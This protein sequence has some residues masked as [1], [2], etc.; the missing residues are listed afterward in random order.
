ME[1]GMKESYRKG[2]ANHPGPESCECSGNDA[3]EA[4]TGVYAGFVLSS[5]ITIP[6][7]RRGQTVRKATR[8]GHYCEPQA[9]PAESKTRACIEPSCA[10]TERPCCCPSPKAEGPV[11][12]GDEP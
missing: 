3:L 10:R 4:L 1:E 5:E 6:G 2:L 7:C 11:G 9:D 12:E 8:L